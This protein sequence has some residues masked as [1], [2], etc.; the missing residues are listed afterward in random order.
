MNTN[1]FIVQ[2][3]L[4]NDFS[5]LGRNISRESFL[6]VNNYYTNKCNFFVSV[7][8]GANVTVFDDQT[9][10]ECLH[11]IKKNLDA[12]YGIGWRLKPLMIKGLLS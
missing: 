11:C 8:F 12:K 6:C 10:Q 3:V 1:K 2:V 5:N 9:F 7:T 4:F